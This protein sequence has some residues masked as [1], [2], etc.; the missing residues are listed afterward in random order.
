MDID[1]KE[2]EK[3]RS[4]N[5]K[6]LDYC[7]ELMM[8]NYIY[9]KELITEREMLEIRSDIEKSYGMKPSYYRNLLGN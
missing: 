6:L 7:Q 8:L 3:F 1:E 9:R 5:K 4:E 2:L